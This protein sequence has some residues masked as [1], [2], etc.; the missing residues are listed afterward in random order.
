MLFSNT[1]PNNTTDKSKHLCVEESDTDINFNVH[2]PHFVNSLE[3]IYNDDA[4]IYMSYHRRFAMKCF[5]FWFCI[6]KNSIGF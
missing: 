3:I 4:V 2:M 6:S 5:N 1:P